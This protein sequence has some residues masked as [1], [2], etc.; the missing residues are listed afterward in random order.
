MRVGPGR[1]VCTFVW[2]FVYLNSMVLMFD[3]VSYEVVIL[4]S[5]VRSPKTLQCQRLLCGSPSWTD[6]MCVCLNCCAF[7]FEV[8][9]GV[10]LMQY[11]AVIS[12][13]CAYWPNKYNG[14]YGSVLQIFIEYTELI[15]F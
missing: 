8:V 4:P 6:S 2:L 15:V 5:C 1:T 9:V 3:A 10:Y 12:P 11:V 13:S 7:A 14:D